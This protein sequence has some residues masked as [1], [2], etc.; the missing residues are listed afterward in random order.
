MKKND[1]GPAFAH[2]GFDSEDSC[3]YPQTGMTLR[4]WF[5]GHAMHAI[6]MDGRDSPADVASRA[7]RFA[8]AMLEKREND[9]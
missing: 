8:D 5:A 1:G 7:Y 6:I 2:S 9:G 4:D 3:A